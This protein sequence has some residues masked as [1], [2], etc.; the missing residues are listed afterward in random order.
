MN[1]Y[2]DLREGNDGSVYYVAPPTKLPFPIDLEHMVVFF[3]PARPGERHGRMTFRLD[4][5]EDDRDAPLGTE[6]T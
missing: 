2:L 3:Y 1:V 6:N 5:A 4:R